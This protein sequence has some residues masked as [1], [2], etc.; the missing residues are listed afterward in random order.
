MLA[1]A[2]LAFNQLFTPPFRAVL[3]KSLALTIGLLVLMIVGLEWAFSTFVQLPGWLETPIAVLGGLGLVVA[4]VFLIAPISAA[5]AGL[6]LDEI[7]AQ[8]ERT[9]YPNDP[10]GKDLPTLQS[11]WL[12]IKFFFV[13]VGVNILILLMLLIPGVNLIA[14][15]LGNGYLL[16]REYFELVA[17][18]HMPR[19]EARQLRRAY[20]FRVLLCGVL[21]AGF[22][23][24]PFLNLLT[25]LFAT[26]F[27]VHMFRSIS[28]RAGAQVRAAA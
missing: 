12:A 24:V 3:F 25:P 13:V 19:E 10:P 7:A 9:Y 16:G 22:V 21:I 15:Y 4:S 27:M 6:Y 1:A 17:L 20:R 8:A 23:S 2:S 5:I 14:F 11:I 28:G 26:A 18:R